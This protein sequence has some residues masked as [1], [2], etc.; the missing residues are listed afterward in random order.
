[1]TVKKTTTGDFHLP[2]ACLNPVCNMN[3]HL[4]RRKNVTDLLLCSIKGE[5]LTIIPK[6]TYICMLESG[7]YFSIRR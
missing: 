4:F 2:Q 1:M 6:S 5:W 7:G 3:I